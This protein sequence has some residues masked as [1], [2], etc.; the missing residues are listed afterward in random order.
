[1]PEA[2]TAL[3]EALSEVAAVAG[4]HGVSLE[5]DIV[6]KT[7]AFIDSAAPDIRPSM[8]RDIEAGRVSELESMVGVVV[9]LGRELAVPT[10]VMRLAYAALLPSYLLTRTAP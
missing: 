5:S 10:P 2:R 8:Q 7:L 1:M 6:S 3:T 4:A 9:K